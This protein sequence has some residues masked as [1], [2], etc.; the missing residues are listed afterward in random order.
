VE[1]DGHDVIV[2]HLRL[3][4]GGDNLRANGPKAQNIVFSHISTTG[5]GDDG[6][7]IAFGAHDVTVQY[8]F[9]A[10]DTPPLF[11][12]SGETTN[13]SVHHNWLVKQWIRGPLI[14]SAVHADLRNNIIQDW[15]GWAERFESE[16][17]G[18][19]VNSLFILGA[20]AR[21][22]GGSTD[23]LR[24]IQLGQV[25]TAGNLDQGAKGSDR[26]ASTPLDAPPA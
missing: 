10:G 18:N 11:L 22:A 16:S 24:L 12:K 23:A 15:D 20:F 9:F 19:V 21:G 26:N 13:I 3:R 7:S 6:I 14:S 17:S 2:R 4:N 8:C 5:S 1:V 25:F